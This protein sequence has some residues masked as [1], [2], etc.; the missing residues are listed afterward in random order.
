MIEPLLFLA[1]VVEDAPTDG[2]AD[3]TARVMAI[4][5][6]AITIGLFVFERRSKRWR[7]RYD[8]TTD[9]R[10]SFQEVHTRIAAAEQDSINAE[11]FWTI[12]VREALSELRNA[13]KTVPDSKLCKLLDQLVKHVT[14][15]RGDAPP[16]PE[17][18]EEAPAPLSPARLTALRSASQVADQIVERLNVIKK[19]GTAG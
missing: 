1:E 2:G 15:A 18:A 8:A 7:G 4:I 14:D 16:T 11:Q 5:G 13:A 17:E 6:W 9:L 19:K 3:V 12:S 10:P